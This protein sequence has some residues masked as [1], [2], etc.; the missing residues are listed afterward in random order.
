MAS[1]IFFLDAATIGSFLILQVILRFSSP[2]KSQLRDQK[3]FC[4]VKYLLKS[5]SSSSY[6]FQLA[7]NDINT[8]LNVSG[9]S[10][11]SLLMFIMHFRM[12]FL[13]SLSLRCGNCAFK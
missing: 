10:Q 6:F 7:L 1:S 3:H 2:F 13:I 12:A 9:G 5:S 11:M 4:F 8:S